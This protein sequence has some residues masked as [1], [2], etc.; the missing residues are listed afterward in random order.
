MKIT[1]YTYEQTTIIFSQASTNDDLY[2]TVTP[3]DLCY[4]Y[5]I[6]IYN[7]FPSVSGSELYLSCKSFSL[8]QFLIVAEVS[9]PLKPIILIAYFKYF[10]KIYKFPLFSQN[11]PKLSFNLIFCL[12]AITKLR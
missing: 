10:H 1:P 5:L 4:V 12:I 2:S 8:Y 11:F 9:I 3:L 6:Q 7:I